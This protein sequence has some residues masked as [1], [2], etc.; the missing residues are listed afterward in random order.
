[1]CP[2]VLKTGQWELP[3]VEHLQPSASACVDL[4]RVSCSQSMSYYW[5]PFCIFC[6]L[7]FGAVGEKAKV[8]VDFFV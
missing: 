6:S 8:G 4:L 3:R 2:K 1:M 5:I 7:T